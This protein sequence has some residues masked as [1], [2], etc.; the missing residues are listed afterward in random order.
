MS[1]DR[2]DYRAI[3]VGLINGPDYQ[4]LTANQ[5]LVLLTLKITFNS[6]G[7]E[8]H[9]P[10]ALAHQLAA[11]TGLTVDQV[12]LSVERLEHDGLLACEGNVVWIPDQLEAGNLS[13]NNPK[14]RA[15]VRNMVAGLPRLSIVGNF[16]RQSDS[17]FK[18]QEKPSNGFQ[19]AFGSQSN[20]NGM[21]IELEDDS[22]TGEDDSISASEDDAVE[23][24]KS[25]AYDTAQRLATNG[26]VIST[27]TV[28]A[29]GKDAKGLLPWGEWLRVV[30]RMAKA[31]ACGYGWP[32]AL[33]RLGEF[34]D[35]AQPDPNR[36]LT[37]AEIESL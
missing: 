29:H 34:R 8:V 37:L 12:R 10:E 23:W 5:R 14:H 1:H 9:Y 22:K 16:I 32:A 30:D 3:R 20:G 35:S 24:P 11:Q 28:G 6:A 18:E 4:R 13:R 25:W 15:A 21:A 31:G 17:W 27:A 7:I 2:G 33:R 19:W 36:E 26:V